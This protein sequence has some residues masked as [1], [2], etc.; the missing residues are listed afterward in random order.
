MLVLKERILNVPIMSLQTGTELARTQTPIIDP[1]ELKI[2]AFY[3]QGSS[4]DINPA[5]LNVEDIREVSGLGF[6]VDDADV[7]MSP[8]DLVRLKQILGY[9]FVL[10]G[11]HVI[12]ENGRKIGK[13]ANYTVDTKSFFIMQLHAQPGL[14]N[15]WDTAEV[16]IGRTQIIEVTDTSVIVRS[17][18][19]RDATPAKKLE[20]LVTN[21][22]KRRR[23]TPEV[24]RPA[25][26]TTTGHPEA[27]P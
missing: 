1:R 22:F 23:G 9:N 10:D 25:S 17:A 15:A 5:I 6:I 13:V 27:Q 4:L 24:P 8:D 21:P 12:E 14:L 7:L 18:V 26:P 2:V 19:V 11:K 16:L 3:C 20:H